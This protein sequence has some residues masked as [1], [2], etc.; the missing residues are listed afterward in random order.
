MQNYT[1]VSHVSERPGPA[2]AVSEART[3]IPGFFFFILVLVYEIRVG[4][5]EKKEGEDEYYFVSLQA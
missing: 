2:Q 4:R 3:Q 5:L 1:S